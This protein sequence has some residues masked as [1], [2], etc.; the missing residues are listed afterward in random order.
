MIK[1]RIYVD[2][3]KSMKEMMDGGKY[4][5]LSNFLRYFELVLKNKTSDGS[6]QISILG[7]S[8]IYIKGISGA[9]ACEFFALN[10]RTPEEVIA[11]MKGAGYREARIEDLFALGEQHPDFQRRFEIVASGTTWRFID[12]GMFVELPPLG[13]TMEEEIEWKQTHK[14]KD[15]IIKWVAVL[16]YEGDGRCLD[17]VAL[18]REKWSENTVFMGVVEE[19]ADPVGF[20][21]E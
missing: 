21:D 18:S 13:M 4:N 19:K 20:V 9:R 17:L 7:L 15:Q 1:K 16:N 2:Y 5:H 12:S 10:G 11:E 8:D 14:L 3:T 6:E